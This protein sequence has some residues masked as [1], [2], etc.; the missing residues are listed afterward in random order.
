MRSVDCVAV[1]IVNRLQPGRKNAIHMKD[2]CRAV[3]C[4]ER[5]VRFAVEYARRELRQPI[6]SD[7]SGYYL[8][9]TETETRNTLRRLEKMAKSLLFTAGVFREHLKE[10]EGQQ[11]FKE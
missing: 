11:T 10:I 3:G 7:N 1:E 5:A 4:D 8:A 6:A 9:E 2:L